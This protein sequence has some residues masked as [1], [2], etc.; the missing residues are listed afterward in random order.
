[1]KALGLAALLLGAGEGPIRLAVAPHEQPRRYA[2]AEWVV[3][4]DVLAPPFLLNEGDRAIP[5][6]WEP[7][8]GGIVLRWVV[9]ELPEGEARTY[10]L[11]RGGGAGA[12]GIQ[13]EEAAEALVVKGS[14]GEI[15]RYR[16]GASLPKPC[17]LPL[18]AHGVPLARGFPVDAREGEPRDHPHHTGLFLGHGDV[19]GRDCWS[20]LPIRHERFLARGSGPV[21]ARI[22]S[23]NLWGEDLVETRDVY[24][25]ETGSDL[26]MDW[27]ITLAARGAPVTI[28]STKEGSFAIR[29]ADGLSEMAGGEMVTSD[30]RRGEEA[31]RSKP[32]AWCDFAGESEGKRVGV[33]ILNHP[34]S[35][36][37]PTDWHV[38][39]YGLL[40][41]NPFLVREA[42]RLEP[43]ESIAL[44]YRVYGH[45][46]DAREGRVAEVFEGYAHPARVTRR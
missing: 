38:R 40:S 31:C 2:L 25:F 9:P 24:L 13:I 8:S 29:V 6:Q 21:Y 11:E 27:T 3:P 17:W 42:H 16:F 18:F 12:A 39:A 23:E 4:A 46:G 1:V 35:F 22:V 37:F 15:A 10:T 32:A 43:G 36:R 41:A 28:G 45:A 5:C 26:V 7:A 33:A 20:A 14:R 44:R 34:E 19:N 30:G